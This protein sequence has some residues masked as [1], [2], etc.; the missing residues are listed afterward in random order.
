[1]AKRGIALTLNVGDIINE[2]GGRPDGEIT[3]SGIWVRGSILL[4]S[5]FG[6]VV[7]SVMSFV[8]VDVAVVVDAGGGGREASFCS[9]IRL[10]VVVGGSVILLYG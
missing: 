2:G 1:M 6:G 7:R 3:S 4:S 10:D 8:I 9:A 5:S